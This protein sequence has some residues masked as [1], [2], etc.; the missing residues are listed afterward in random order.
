MVKFVECCGYSVPAWLFDFLERHD[1]SVRAACCVCRL[2]GLVQCEN[3]LELTA[4][5][6]DVVEG[7]RFVRNCGKRTTAEI[8]Q[9]VL[10]K[11]VVESLVD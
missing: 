3:E 1:L 11:I 8:A 7:R 10:S 5:L 4:F 6:E 9:K 2:Y